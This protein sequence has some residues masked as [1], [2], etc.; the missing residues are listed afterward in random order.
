MEENQ[1]DFE[2][3]KWGTFS[4]QFKAYQA[5]HPKSQ[6][7]SIKDFAENINQ[8]PHHYKEHTQKRARQHLAKKS[9]QQSKPEEGGLLSAE[10]LHDLIQS[11]YDA[12]THDLADFDADHDLSDDRVKVYKR[13]G[14]SN[15]AVV[16]HRGTQ[17]L[18]DQLL[19]AQYV[20]GKDINNSERFKHAAD[21]QRKAEAKYGAHNI[22][23][24][25][26]SLGSKIASDVGQNSKEIINLNKAV[27]SR[28]IGKATSAKETNIRTK[29]DPVSAAMSLFS[30][31][32]NNQNTFTIPST[33]INPLKEHS[34]DVLKR[35]DPKKMFGVA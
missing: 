24:V 19:D 11:S 20:M 15:Q 21:I 9:K 33:S 3:K 34:S 17:G 13:K 5:Q 12:K 29:Y 4:K 18:S 35:I 27:A 1:E 7:R 23:T 30:N 32:N 10:E 2:N 25:G 31:K 8:Y 14:N 6:L 22:S 28:D 26:H 16:V